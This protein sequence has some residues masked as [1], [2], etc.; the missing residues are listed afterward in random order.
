MLTIKKFKTSLRPRNWDFD[1]KVTDI[2]PGGG[3]SQTVPDE[4]WTI[5][6]LMERHRRGL[7]ENVQKTPIWSDNVTHDSVDLEKVPLMDVYEKTQFSDS[8]QDD[9]NRLKKTVEKQ[10]AAMAQKQRAKLEEKP[11]PDE[12]SEAPKKPGTLELPST[13]V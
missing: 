10:K 1:L 9:I 2:E 7:L 3:I 6:Q 5:N 11:A 12:K 8:V 13:G 4:S